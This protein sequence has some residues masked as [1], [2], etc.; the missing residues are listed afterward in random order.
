[1]NYSILKHSSGSNRLI[2]YRAKLGP[3]FYYENLNEADITN[4][5]AAR[6]EI[7]RDDFYIDRLYV[8]GDRRGSFRTILLQAAF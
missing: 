7:P 3:P 4:I 8:W 2:I 5:L 6:P 1:M